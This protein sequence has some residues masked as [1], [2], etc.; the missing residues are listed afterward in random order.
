MKKKSTKPYWEMNAR[1]LATATKEFEKDFVL[2]TFGP[3]PPTARAEWA[4]AL[5]KRRGSRTSARETIHVSIDRDLLKRAD[6]F[7]DRNGLSRE[8]VIVQSVESF[9]SRTN[10]KPRR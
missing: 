2:D 9:I 5:R 10:G 6:V 3:P 4:K 1:E 7:A 8:Q